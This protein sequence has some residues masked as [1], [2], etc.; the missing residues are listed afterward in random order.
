MFGHP[1][2]SNLNPLYLTAYRGE[3]L[4]LKEVK[5]LYLTFILSKKQ[6]IVV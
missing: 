3:K 6:K 2:K 4:L 1:L 5:N